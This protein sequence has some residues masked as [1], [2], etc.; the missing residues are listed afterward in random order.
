MGAERGDE[1][2]AGDNDPAQRVTLLI[3][4]SEMALCV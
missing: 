2:E 4:G 3:S 1:G